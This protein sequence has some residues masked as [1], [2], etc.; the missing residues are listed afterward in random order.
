MTTLTQGQLLNFFVFLLVVSAPTVYAFVP[1]LIEAYM[2]RRR[3][4][5]PICHSL[6]GWFFESS[7]EEL[8]YTPS[9]PAR[10]A[11]TVWN[12]GAPFLGDERAFIDVSP[13]DRKKTVSM[14]PLGTRSLTIATCGISI[15]ALSLFFFSLYNIGT[16]CT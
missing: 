4:R 12:S 14:C 1:P 10:L 7:Y 13:N 16:L 5:K 2:I 3:T 11:G 9:I 6:E 8:T 15:C